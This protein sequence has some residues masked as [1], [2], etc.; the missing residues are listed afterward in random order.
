MAGRI[1]SN[2]PAGV[3]R[4]V[5][6]AAAEAFQAD[7]YR[8]ATMQD[9]IRSAGVSGGAVYH[10]FPTKTRLALAV[11]VDHVGGEV[12]QTWKAVVREAPSCAEGVLAAFDGVIAQLEAAGVVRGC[13]L[14]NLALELCLA[15]PGLREA[16]DAQYRDWRATVEQKLLADI[17]QGAA[18]YAGDDPAAFAAMVVSAYSG[19]IAMAKAEQG[20]SAL[21]ACRA[22]LARL[23]A[24]DSSRPV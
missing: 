17:D 23:M 20:T 21:R 6:E 3:R 8:G 2:D 9:I 13:P 24:S 14:A 15:D 19:A 22:Q 10:H 16:I 11:V 12:E 1:R 7:G 18:A 4:R 5:V